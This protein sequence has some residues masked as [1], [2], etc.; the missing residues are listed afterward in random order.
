MENTAPQTQ[1]Y[2]VWKNDDYVGIIWASSAHG[3]RSEN[4][5]A[6]N[7]MTAFFDRH[8]VAVAH[9]ESVRWEEVRF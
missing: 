4:P 5:Y 8:G 7:L 2:K 3:C 1:Y 6:K 9:V